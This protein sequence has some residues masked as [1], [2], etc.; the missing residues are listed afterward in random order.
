[1]INQ[2]EKDRT[3]RNINVAYLEIESAL[4]GLINV[5]KYATTPRACLREMQLG[6]VK[7]RHEV[8]KL[9]T[10]E[11]WCAENARR[12]IVPTVKEN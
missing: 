11:E 12:C 7:V 1:M 3:L 9:E 8:E 5:E 10:Y 6:L 2:L 4:T